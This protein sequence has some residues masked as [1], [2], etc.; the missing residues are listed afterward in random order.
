MPATK[1]G[2][3]SDHVELQAFLGRAFGP[4]VKTQTIQGVL[5]EIR[6]AGF[7]MKEG[8][9]IPLFAFAT[10]ED[11]ANFKI[12]SIEEAVA[13]VGIAE[14]RKISGTSTADKR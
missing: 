3:P 13:L 8:E 4:V 7:I 9:K 10:P 11:P 1:K 14:I 5:L 12:I 6:S 2:H